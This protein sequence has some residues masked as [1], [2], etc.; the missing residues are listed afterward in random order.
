M[1]SIINFISYIR[2]D[3]S[4]NTS[5]I[6]IITNPFLSYALQVVCPLPLQQEGK[7]YKEDI[8]TFT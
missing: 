5:M 7:S 6:S 3:A 4:Q 2:Q 8:V 1:A